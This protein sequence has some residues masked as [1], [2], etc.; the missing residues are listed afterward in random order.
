[1]RQLNSILF[2]FF[3]LFSFQIHTSE[4]T[5]INTYFYSNF[6]N[7][8]YAYLQLNISL[9]LTAT[10]DAQELSNGSFVCINTPITANAA[11]LSMFNPY[12]LIVELPRVGGSPFNLPSSQFPQNILWMSQSEFYANKTPYAKFGSQCIAYPT[13]QPNQL[14]PYNFTATY[15]TLISSTSG[16]ASLGT[17]CY[18]N[19]SLWDGSNQVAFSFTPTVQGNRLLTL[20]LTIGECAVMTHA[21]DSSGASKDCW[22]H[23][24]LL[25]NRVFLDSL[26]LTYVSGPSLSLTPL[27]QDPAVPGQSYTMVVNVTNNGD[28][29]A[30]I[31][32]VNVSYSGGQI[33]VNDFSPS[34]VLVG[35]TV[36]LRIN[37]TIPSSIT[38]G[39]VIY[40]N[41]SIIYNSS[42]PVVGDCGG[43]RS[44]TGSI[45]TNGIVV[46]NV[47]P[48]TLTARSSP[49]SILKEGSYYS[50]NKII[51]NITIRR[52]EPPNFR[53]DYV[54][55]NITLYYYNTTTQ[56]FKLNASY[57]GI[58]GSSGSY[59]SGDG[60]IRWSTDSDGLRIQYNQTIS[61]YLPGV[62]KINISSYDPSPTDDN[63]QPNPV[64][65]TR[66]FY[67][68]I[69]NASSCV[70]RI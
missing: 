46:G 40:P 60:N 3:F 23:N 17:F 35:Q 56:S 36:Q 52:D 61:N 8:Y 31:N 47:K 66:Q 4:A 68:V 30:T 7:D 5:L 12:S 28:L 48:I 24:T 22:Y 70:K 6:G 19:L 50:S 20:N 64:T 58:S 18:G 44:V 14:A 29:N 9:N 53:L 13:T 49:S 25:N 42:T 62:Y 26:N 1:M 33:P 54:E 65:R 32:Q 34:S 21:F 59:S 27:P 67:F 39:T 38:P 15:K 57:T 43:S 55:T 51:T 2:L 45:S 11:N 41:V 16:T 69:F 37:V 10:S 63:G